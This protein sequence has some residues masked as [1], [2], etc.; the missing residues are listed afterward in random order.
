MTTE[1]LLVVVPTAAEGFGIDLAQTP[2]EGADLPEFGTVRWHTLISADRTPSEELTLGVAIF[3]PGDTLPP[4]RHGPAEFYFGLD[5]SGT[6]TV[7]G[8]AH[9]LGPGRAVFIPCNAE[10]GVVAGP[11][12]LRMAYGF[13]RASFAEVDYH[14]S[15]PVDPASQG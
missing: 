6:A 3:G 8:V 11:E 5:G 9:P 15:P 10:H 4:H 7:D 2:Q 12:G 1:A 13:A 14:F